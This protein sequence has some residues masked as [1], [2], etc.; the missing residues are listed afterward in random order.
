MA[1]NPMQ[2][3]ANNSFI[4][5]ILVT[6]LITGCII[7][8]LIMQ[9]SKVNKEMEEMKASRESVYVLK[10]AVKSGD[11][12]TE[13]MFKKIEV[14]SGT[15]P[16]NA[17]TVKSDLANY[18]ICDKNE[19]PIKIIGVDSEGNN[20]YAIVIGEQ[21]VALKKDT[22]SGEYYYENRKSDGTTENVYVEFLNQPLL[23]KVD[24]EANTL[25]TD[26]VIRRGALVTDDV[27]TQEYNIITLPTQ[28]ASGDVIDVRLRLPDGQDYIVVSHK[29]VTVPTIGNIDSASCIWIEMNETETLSMSAAIIEAYQMIGAKLYATKYVEAGNQDAAIPTYL[30]PDKTLAFMQKNPNALE[31]AKR[32]IFARNNDSDYKAT[33]RNP[34]NSAVNNEDAQDNV[35]DKVQ[36]E[37]QGLQE[38]REQYLDSLDV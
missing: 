28:L 22:T 38:E 20:Q 10:Q 23:A 36:E 9:L 18:S 25:I 34:I 24:L 3:K 26:S 31:E 6:L 16:Q 35:E 19:R 11:L 5:G 37:I 4:L 27:R 33:V 15:I 12:I 17:I 21:D 2:R 8:F 7:G 13:E 29:T 30:P 14:D 1:I 32:E